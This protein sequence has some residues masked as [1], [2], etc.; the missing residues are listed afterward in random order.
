[1]FSGFTFNRFGSYDIGLRSRR[2][3]LF[4]LNNIGRNLGTNLARQVIP[5]GF[6]FLLF[7]VSIRNNVSKGSADGLL[8]GPP[9]LFAAEMWATLASE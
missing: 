4:A 8:I 6:V 9:I 1:M 2:C 3:Y 7:H 5:I